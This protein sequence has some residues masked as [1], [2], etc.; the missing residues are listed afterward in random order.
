MNPTNHWLSALASLRTWIFPLALICLAW[1]VLG[2]AGNPSE[3]LV[4]V[5]RPS[6][7]DPMYVRSILVARQ[8]P[9]G[10]Y[11]GL[12]LNK[13][14]E[15]KLAQAF[16]DNEASSALADPLYLGGPSV[17]NTVF[18]LVHSPTTPAEGAIALTGDLYLAISESAIDNAMAAAPGEPA[19]FFIGAVMWQSGELDAEI[20]QGAWYVLKPTPEL[21][22]PARTS[23]LWVDLVRQAQQ[24]AKWI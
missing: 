8:L 7:S 13:P 2:Y 18:A 23:G 1:N 17:G 15:L 19:R 14:T 6:V 21:V 11:V 4:L 10:R 3:T 5:A 24:A 22:L 20:D 16:P 9:G 12:I